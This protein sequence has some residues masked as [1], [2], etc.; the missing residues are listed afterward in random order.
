MVRPLNEDQQAR[1]EG[2]RERAA[3]S[4]YMTNVL[5]DPDCPITTQQMN[6]AKMCLFHLEPQVHEVL[7]KIDRVYDEPKQKKLRDAL[8]LAALMALDRLLT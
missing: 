6:E 3:A 2:R 8:L 5:T 4:E 1:A 7:N